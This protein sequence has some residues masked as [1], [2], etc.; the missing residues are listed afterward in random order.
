MKSVDCAA[1]LKW[2]ILPSV[3]EAGATWIRLQDAS[4]S[5]FGIPWSP[6]NPRAQRHRGYEGPKAAPRLIRG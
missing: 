5:L 6:D 2:L 1:H 3:D 4:S